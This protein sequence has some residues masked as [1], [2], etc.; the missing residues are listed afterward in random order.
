MKV[1]DEGKLK[2]PQCK[3]SSESHH[4][5]AQIQ[6]KSGIEDLRLPQE[7]KNLYE[8]GHYKY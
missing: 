2:I 1:L 8:D 5:F 6:L 7:Q 4:D 3:H